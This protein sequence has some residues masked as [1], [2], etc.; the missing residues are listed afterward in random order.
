[1]FDLIRELFARCRDKR[2]KARLFQELDIGEGT[3]VGLLNLDGMFPHLV[4]IGRNC[5]F[6]PG[7][8]VLTHDASYFLFTNEY[9]VAPVSIG[10][11]CFIGY[12]AVILPGI[13]VGDNVVIGA[14]SVVTKDVPSD[15][16]ATGVPAKVISSL[17]EYLENRKDE[18]MFAP[19]FIDK[20]VSKINEDDIADFRRLIYP[21]LN[22]K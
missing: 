14:G 3:R 20:Q 9:R 2:R 16:V 19:P 18:Q 15:S 4:H 17:Q 13:T 12:G 21:K 10:D 6:A 11:N 1:M 7:S 8:M 22:K 5:I